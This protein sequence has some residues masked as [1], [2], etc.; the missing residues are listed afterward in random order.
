MEGE[1]RERGKKK[2][3]NFLSW[4]FAMSKKVL[5]NGKNAT[6]EKVF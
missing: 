3:P 1:E 4:L 5:C 6:L 2:K